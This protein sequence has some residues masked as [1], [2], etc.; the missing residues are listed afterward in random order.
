MNLSLKLSS[1]R[2]FLN[3]LC[4][5][6]YFTHMYVCK[7]GTKRKNAGWNCDNRIDF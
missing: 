7:N 4:L 3:D 1:F 2:E 6:I 5:F